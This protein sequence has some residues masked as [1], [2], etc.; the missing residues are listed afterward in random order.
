[1]GSPIY[2]ISPHINDLPEFLK[3]PALVGLFPDRR[4]PTKVIIV[5]LRPRPLP[6]S[7]RR[8]SARDE[9][10]FC[11]NIG[12][13]IGYWKKGDPLFSDGLDVAET[14]AGEPAQPRQGP[15]AT[16]IV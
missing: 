13:F 2:R 4:T 14:V 12:P 5:E 11:G 7:A 15:L 10:L 1:M 16:I 8:N 9:G 3:I 6:P